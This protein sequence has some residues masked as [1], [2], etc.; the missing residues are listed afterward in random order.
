MRGAVPLG[1]VYR[2]PSYISTGAPPWRRPSLRSTIQ[3]MAPAAMQA[4]RGGM[5]AGVES[6]LDLLS[7]P[8][9][10]PEKSRKEP[11]PA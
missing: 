8:R 5:I 6:P 1:R 10:K 4:G 2:V 11:P 3:P 9:K 7:Q